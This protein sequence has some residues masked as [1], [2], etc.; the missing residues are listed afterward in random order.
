MKAIAI[1]D[2]N[3]NLSTKDNPVIANLPEDKRFFREQTY[4][5]IV[6]MGR[7]TAETFSKFG[8]KLPNRKN[9]ILTKNGTFVKTVHDFYKNNDTEKESMP[10][11]LNSIPALFLFL[12]DLWKK[13]IIKTPY[14]N[15]VF[16]IGGGNIYH[17][18]VPYCNEIFLSRVNEIF[19]TQENQYVLHEKGTNLF[20]DIEEHHPFKLMSHKTIRNLSDHTDEKYLYRCDVEAY[21]RNDSFLVKLNQYEPGCLTYENIYF[22]HRRLHIKNN[23]FMDNV[24]LS[25]EDIWYQ[26]IK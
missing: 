1:V 24:L 6:I 4:G 25:D 3:Y 23:T 16:V 26:D 17:Q 20:P 14:M 10:V 18:L 13:E 15:E 19:D 9:I 21:E 11:M 22:S 7:K 8:Y 12:Y 2:K 5:K